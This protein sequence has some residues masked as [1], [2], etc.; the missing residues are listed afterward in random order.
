MNFEYDKKLDL[1]SGSSLTTWFSI[2]LN[3]FW[4]NRGSGSSMFNRIICFG[5]WFV[6]TKNSGLNWFR[7][8]P[9]VKPWCCDEYGY[10]KSRSCLLSKNYWKILKLNFYRTKKNVENS[11]G[12]QISCVKNV[13][14][15]YRSIFFNHKTETKSPITNSHS[16][17]ENFSNTQITHFGKTTEFVKTFLRPIFNFLVY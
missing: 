2:W 9:G 11:N 6:F 17:Y 12:L 5:F 16:L 1:D 10:S 7:L 15:L 4:N 13:S 8:G 3:W 14:D